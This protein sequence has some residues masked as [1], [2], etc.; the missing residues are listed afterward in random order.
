MCTGS[1]LLM[2]DGAGAPTTVAGDSDTGKHVTAPEAATC[3]VFSLRKS[4]DFGI[5]THVVVI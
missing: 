4:L 1:P 2:V 5:V 3:A